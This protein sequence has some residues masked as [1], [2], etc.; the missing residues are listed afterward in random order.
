METDNTEK[1]ATYGIQ[2][3]DSVVSE[4]GRYVMIIR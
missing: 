4:N 3:E 2:N 1:L